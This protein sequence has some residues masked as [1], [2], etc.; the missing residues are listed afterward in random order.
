MNFFPYLG[1]V[2]LLTGLAP[3][4]A[5][6]LFFQAGAVEFADITISGT[7]VQRSVK[8][9]DGTSATQT[10]PVANIIRVDF[11]K[12]DDLSAADDLI[13]HDGRTIFVSLTSGH[14]QHIEVI[15]KAFDGAF[16]RRRQLL[17]DPLIHALRQHH[18]M[19]ARPRAESA[20]IQNMPGE[21]DG[22]SRLGI[23]AYHRGLGVIQ[24]PIARAAAR[25]G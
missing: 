1:G 7:N 13:L 20:A 6:T 22:I 5:Q 21:I 15:Q 10:I 12:P 3:L 25:Q 2:A 19:I 4:P 11:P 23:A 24:Q 8:R 14:M 17:V 16:R 9:P 18:R